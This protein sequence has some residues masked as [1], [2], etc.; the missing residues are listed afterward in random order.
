[1]FSYTENDFNI[2]EDVDIVS[3]NTVVDKIVA[4][5]NKDIRNILITCWEDA[6]I[7]YSTT[8]NIFYKRLNH[9]KFKYELKIKNPRGVAKKVMFRIWLGLLADENDVKLYL[10]KVFKIEIILLFQYLPTPAHD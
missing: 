1:M 3:V 10:C 5:S 2:N 7:Q 6:K 8:S 4:K 9:L